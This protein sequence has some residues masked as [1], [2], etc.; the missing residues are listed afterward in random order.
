MRL[1]LKNTL[2]LLAGYGSLLLVL[3][4]IAVFQLLILQANEQKE[5]ARLFAHEVAS[6]LAEPSLDRL[7]QA[8]R[9]TR[10]NLRTLIEQLSRNS[11]VVTSIS[12]IDRTGR[13]VAS[14]NPGVG[15]RLSTPDEFFG[16]SRMMRF[17]T[18]GAFPF[19]SGRYQLAVPLIEKD[20]R[21][22]YLLIDIQSKGVAEMN[23]RMWNSLFSYALVGL[24]CITGLGF[25]LHFQLA[26]RG[27]TL[28]RTLE[29]ALRGESPRVAPEID[30]FSQAIAT[31]G[32]AG[33][34]IDR[35]QRL[36]AAEHGRFVTL[37]HVLNVGVL[38][39]DPQGQVEF[40][41][42][43]ARELFGCGTQEALAAA[44]S[45]LRP[46]L[47][48]GIRHSAPYGREGMRIDL[49]PP[50]RPGGRVR[51]EVYPLEQG[52]GG[53]RLV[54][55]RDL[56]TM[57][58]IEND[59]RLA[60]QLRGLARLYLSVA[61]DIRAPLAAIV[62]HLELLGASVRSDGSPDE[63][64][65]ERR[66]AYLSVLDQE[67]HRLRRSL[68]SLLDHTTLP[69]DELEELDVRDLV[70]GI[71][72][73]LRP[74]CERQKIALSSAVPDE[75]VR[76][77]A[78]RDALKQ[79]LLNIGINALES[80]PNG[81]TLALRLEARDSRVVLSVADS[82]PGIPPELTDRIFDMHFSTKPGGSGIGL[83]IARAVVEASGGEIRVC[84]G[85]EQGSTFVIG[86]PALS[87]GA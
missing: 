10:Q 43:R 41:S 80:M 50:A 7:L 15:Q 65:K 46:E 25:A 9:T 83:H 78:V 61:H 48:K 45:A 59:L 37:G 19:Y 13:V 76:A 32:R 23:R 47:E 49:E 67:I 72:A 70:R 26:R 6:A 31:A 82:G 38:L 44:F 36:R 68:D 75:P 74:Q 11:Q 14:D 71:E 56:A 87:R 30:E 54:L 27:R 62:A 22:G 69:R 85:S 33:V 64:V 16:A 77:L 63:S 24:V 18:F 4:G 2:F 51:L 73:L 34:E 52:E 28:A 60:S 3:G 81:G 5:V 53:G 39:V 35:A 20:A 57:K 79:A 86:L 40:A 12:V 66:K 58:A 1:A 55:V 42:T 29:A 17:T 8:D 84:R 21:V